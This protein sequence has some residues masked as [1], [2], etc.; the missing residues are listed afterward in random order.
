MLVK[1]AWLLAGEVFTE[2]LVLIEH[3]IMATVIV[4]L[5]VKVHVPE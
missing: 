1:V 5:V 4:V 2:K 3:V